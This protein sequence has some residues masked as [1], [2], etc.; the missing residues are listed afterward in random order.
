MSRATINATLQTALLALAAVLIWQFWLGDPCLDNDLSNRLA[1][2]IPAQTSPA[3]ISNSIVIENPYGKET[4]DVWP[5]AMDSIITMTVL[6][7]VLFGVGWLS[8]RR[9]PQR[10]Y[11]T[12]ASVTLFALT[13]SQALA[14][15]ARFDEF[16][17][18]FSGRVGAAARTEVLAL[19]LVVFAGG[20]G[21]AT[22][23]AWLARRRQS[24][25]TKV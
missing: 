8:A 14:I 4:C 22:L 18:L 15:F 9:L 19:L 6:A 11:L 20:A 3:T 24:T 25:V 21:V 1:L 13:V 2:N 10:P 17:S 16:E 12:A 23:G 5:T 7:L